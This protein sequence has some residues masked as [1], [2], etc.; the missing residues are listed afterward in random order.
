MC[1]LCERTVIYQCTCV[2]V[3]HYGILYCDILHLYDISYF[4]CFNIHLFCAF[5]WNTDM[6]YDI[7]HLIIN[8]NMLFNFNFLFWKYN[9]YM[10]I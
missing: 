3:H 9:L 5:V 10:S 4:W 6:T 8:L 1:M 2:F 7:Y